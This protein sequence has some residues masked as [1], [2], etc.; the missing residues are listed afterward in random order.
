MMGEQG[1][2]RGWQVDWLFKASQY[3]GMIPDCQKKVKIKNTN[4]FLKKQ[5]KEKKTKKILKKKKSALKK[6]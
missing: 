5:R 2:I 3:S 1:R 4:Q 6:P